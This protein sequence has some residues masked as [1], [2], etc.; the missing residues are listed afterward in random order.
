M[1]TAQLICVFVFAFAK[2]RFSHNEAQIFMTTSK[3]LTASAPYIQTRHNLVHVHI[4]SDLHVLTCIAVMY[5][6][7]QVQTYKTD[8]TSV[9]MPRMSARA[10]VIKFRKKVK[11]RKKLSKYTILLFLSVVFG[12]VQFYF[13]CFH[14]KLC[15]ITSSQ[16]EKN[17]KNNNKKSIK[18]RRNHKSGLSVW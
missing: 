13:C 5:M 17:N 9:Y 7:S 14:Y 15:G 4:L 10:H 11:K 1:V 12:K 16:V 3:T 18:T 6:H 8:Q 2:R